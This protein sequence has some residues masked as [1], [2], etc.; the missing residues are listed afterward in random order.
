M[1]LEAQLRS[2]II[3]AGGPSDWA[4]PFWNYFAA[5]N[6]VMPKAFS[7]Q[8]MDDG[9]PNPLFVTMRYGPKN[10][11]NIYIPLGTGRG[12]VNDL[13]MANDLFTG[14]NSVTKLPGF[15]GG[16][17]GFHHTN[18]GQAAGNMEQNPHNFVHGAIG[19][20]ISQTEWGL[21][22]DPG[23]AALDPIFYLHHANIDR[24]WAVWNLT[25]S[26]TTNAA[27]LNG[28]QP[29]QRQFVMPNS[30]TGASGKWGY[31]PADVEVLSKLN[32]SYD[33]MSGVGAKPKSTLSE[34]LTFL[35]AEVAEAL[36]KT[37]RVSTEP[38]EL[39]GASKVALT[40]HGPAT[41]TMVKLDHEMKGSVVQSLLEAS[42]EALPDTVYL[43]LENVQGTADASILSVY[44][45]LPEG[46]NPNNH[47]ECF[48]GSISLFGVRRASMENGDHGGQ[49][50]TFVLDIT[51][52]FDAMHIADELASD[53]LRVSIFPD[54]DLSAE[55]PITVGRISVYRQHQ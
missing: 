43:K 19:G 38:I 44:A 18:S 23:I 47:P 55:T 7:Q 17:T 39:V 3:A 11:G 34:R 22:S 27:W 6:N 49:G 30:P 15:G 48:V 33:D 20:Q 31:T 41:H 32:Y 52:V 28:P 16:Q 21:M 9:T 2:D 8:T 26:N 25:N 14:S 35:G 53:S 13:C 50:L 4:L 1:A 29:P 37:G 5:N 45:N 10:D 42:V 46:S 51:T 54:N 24:M 12:E 40:I 36:P